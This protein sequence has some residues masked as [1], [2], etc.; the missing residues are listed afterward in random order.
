MNSNSQSW[1]TYQNGLST[2]RQGGLQD[3]GSYCNSGVSVFSFKG[4]YMTPMGTATVSIL[5]LYSAQ[6][7]PTNKPRRFLRRV[8]T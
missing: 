2:A 4:V 6:N 8:S 1:S 3:T 7:H 5:D